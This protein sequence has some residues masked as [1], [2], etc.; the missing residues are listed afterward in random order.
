MFLD[1]IQDCIT[2]ELP[3]KGVY[4]QGEEFLESNSRLQ[5]GEHTVFLNRIKLHY[6][7]NCLYLFSICNSTEFSAS[8]ILVWQAELQEFQMSPEALC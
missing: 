7:M 2:G 8:Q 3:I 6:R 1:A 5:P 4:S